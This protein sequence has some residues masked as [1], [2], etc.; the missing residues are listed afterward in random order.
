MDNWKSP[1]IVGISVVM[2]ASCGGGDSTGPTYRVGGIVNGLAGS[3]LVLQATGSNS[4]TVSAAGRFQFPTGLSNGSAY[5]ITVQTQPTSPSQSCSVSPATGTI[6]GADVTNIVVTCATNSY[7]VGGTVSGLDGTGLVLQDNG[8]DTLG[9]SSNRQFAFAVP[10]QSGATYSVTVQSQPISSASGLSQTCSVASGAGTMAAADVTTVTVTC[11]N[12]ALPPGGTTLAIDDGRTMSLFRVSPNWGN[13]G[14]SPTPIQTIETP[15]ITGIAADPAGTIYYTANSGITGSD[16]TFYVCPA[17]A[18]GQSYTCAPA[19]NTSKIAGGKLLVFDEMSGNLLAAQVAPIGTTIVEFSSRAGPAGSNNRIIYTSSG[20]PATVNAQV[21]WTGNIENIF[22]TEIPAGSAFGSGVKAFG[23]TVPCAAG[24]QADIT[25][26]LIASVGTPSRLSGALSGRYSTLI[27]GLANAYGA[28]AAPTTLPTALRCGA[29]LNAAQNNYYC[30]PIYNTVRSFPSLAG[31]LS[32]F[33]A[34]PGLAVDTAGQLYEAA[35]LTNQG[36]TVDPSLLKGYQFFGFQPDSS[37]A[38]SCS[39]TPAT[40]P[41]DLLPSV[42]VALDGSVAPY[43]MTI[44]R[45]CQAQNSGAGTYCGTFKVIWANQNGSQ[46]T[47]SLDGMFWFTTQATAGSVG[48]GGMGSAGLLA[49]QI[50]VLGSPGPTTVG[51]DDGS[52]S[53][54]AGSV[55]LGAFGGRLNFTGAISGSSVSGTITA[56]GYGAGNLGGNAAGSGSFTGTAAS[57]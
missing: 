40:C 39:D 49:C 45:N 23:C 19:P 17:V 41:V 10:F 36:Q 52:F 37:A 14:S 50:T 22:V 55:S 32:P 26:S 29:Q 12:S 18:P 48:T 53:T 5:A 16:A 24:T 44:S 11:S 42:P 31:N 15:N 3:G 33:I 38:F 9:I 56:L 46:G 57:R 47:T 43:L 30:F 51:C 35:A 6:A 13:V 34:T 1:A 4:V 54:V 8:S 2:L 27:V 20:T 25:Q 7:K 28:T 21:L